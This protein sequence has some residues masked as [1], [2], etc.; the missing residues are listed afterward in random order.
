MSERR[1]MTGAELNEWFMNFHL[2]NP[3]IYRAFKRMAFEMRAEG[4]RRYGA[5]TIMERLRWESE[6]RH[7]GEKFKLSN[8]IK[9]RCSA[10]YAR[11]MIEE[12]PSF[13][14]F[15]QLKPTLDWF[16]RLKLSK[17][18]TKQLKRSNL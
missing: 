6:V 14:S 13:A 11:K 1:I 12:Y 2:K 3:H 9:D 10:R 5:K 18:H 16:K 15:F 4:H 8:T 7:P 17:A